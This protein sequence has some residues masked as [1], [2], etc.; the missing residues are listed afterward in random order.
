MVKTTTKGRSVTLCS[1]SSW[2]PPA[3][4]PGHPQQTSTEAGG[5][6]KAGS[7]APLG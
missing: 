7:R 6:G 4:G 2:K 5:E 3:E 1:H